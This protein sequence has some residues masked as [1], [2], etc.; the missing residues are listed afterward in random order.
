VRPWSFVYVLFFLLAGSSPLLAQQPSAPELYPVE[1]DGK[2]GYIDCSGRI[3]IP[4]DYDG[5]DRFGEGLAR[6]IDDHC[7]RRRS[8]RTVRRMRTLQN[9]YLQ[10]FTLNR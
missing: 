10:G 6:R 4:L 7:Y 1:R 8:R 9:P 3:A 2:H 5:A